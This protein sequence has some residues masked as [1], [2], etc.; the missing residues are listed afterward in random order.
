MHRQPTKQ[1]NKVR[2]REECEPG[3]RGRGPGMGE[4]D[5]SRE[6]RGCFMEEV[7]LQMSKIWQEEERK[8]QAEE[9]A[10]TKA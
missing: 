7:T 10:Q 1:Q 8:H 2:G 9:T 5:S 3:V 6:I 4:R